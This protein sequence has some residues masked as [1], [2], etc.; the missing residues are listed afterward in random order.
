MNPIE[1]EEGT[2]CTCTNGTTCTCAVYADSLSLAQ[3]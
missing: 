1:Q 3:D 2:H